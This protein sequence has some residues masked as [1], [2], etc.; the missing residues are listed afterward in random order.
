MSYEHVVEETGLKV[1]SF[2]HHPV[3]TM[4]AIIHEYC[5]SLFESGQ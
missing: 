4:S 2:F 1:D 5:H 3:T